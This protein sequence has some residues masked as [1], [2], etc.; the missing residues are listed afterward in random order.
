[1][2]RDSTHIAVAPSGVSRRRLSASTD[3]LRE[4]VV[5]LAGGRASSR[6]VIRHALILATGSG[7]A[8]AI[9]VASVPVITRLYT[10]EQFGL[11]ALF[12]SCVAL[13]TPFASLRYSAALPLPKRDQGAVALLMACMLFLG[14]FIALLAVLIALFSGELLGLVSAQALVPLWPLLLASVATA[15]LH[16]ILSS[17]SVREKHFGLM[18]R[19]DVSQ[20]L[21]GAAAKIGLALGA[22]QHLGLYVGHIA[23]QAAAS[24]LLARAAW[25]SSVDVARGLSFGAVKQVV[26]RYAGFPLYRLPSQVLMTIG[27]QAPLLFVSAT[28]GSATAGQLGLALVALALP[29]TLI[30]QNAG[31]AYYAEIAR[32]GRGEPA[33]IYQVSREVTLRLLALAV[34][35]TGILMLGGATL[36]SLFFGARWHDAG[37]FAGILAIYLPAQFVANLLSHALSVLDRQHVYLRLNALRVVMIVGTFAIAHQ[38]KLSAFE[39]VAAYSAV[40]SAHYVATSITIFTIIRRAVAT[41]GE[42]AGSPDA[43]SETLQ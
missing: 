35:P 12:L 26:R 9:G 28:Y 6:D 8:K 41:P 2:Q 3:G 43:R 40:L 30:G 32:V 19:A 27:Q 33:R 5:R 21:L 29:L 42:A 14:L 36:F 38:L 7:A 15:G 20:S 39:T 37:A 13:L 16:E 17:W 25:R 1:M 24:V 10:P 23:A 4:R 11:F 31:Q 22:F 34:V 18:A